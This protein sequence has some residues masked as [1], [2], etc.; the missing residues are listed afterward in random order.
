MIMEHDNITDNDNNAVITMMMMNHNKWKEMKMPTLFYLAKV[1]VGFYKRRR[2]I[3]C[4][5]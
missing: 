3:L 1:H 4:A 2:R 5:V